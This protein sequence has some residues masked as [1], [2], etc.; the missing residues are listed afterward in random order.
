[1]SKKGKI[2]S[3]V[4]IMLIAMYAFSLSASA[5]LLGKDGFY[6]EF[7]NGNA[8]LKEYHSSSVTV[9]IPNQVYSHNVTKIADYAFLRNTNITSVTIPDTVNKIGDSAFYGCSNLEK[10][11]IPKSVI[12]FGNSIFA[13]C[14]KLTIYC[15]SGSTAEKYAIANNAAYKL[16]DV[17]ELRN[18]STI[19]STQLNLGDTL[20]IN[21]AASGGSGGYTY[22]FYY[23]QSQNAN[24]RKI[25]A[26][27]AAVSVTLKPQYLTTYD[28]MVTV[29]DGNAQVVSKTFKVTVSEE[30]K[31][32]SAI[33]TTQ[34]IKGETLTLTGAASGGSG[35]Y[36]YA[37]YY[38][39]ASTTG[40]RVIGELYGTATTATLKPSYLTE[41]DIMI[42]V[43]DSTNKMVSKT[44]K[45]TVS[46][47]L[48]NNSTISTTQ[49]IKGETLTLTGAAEGGSGEYKYAF[50]YK[51]ASTTGWRAIGELYGTATTATLKPSYLTEYDIM[52]RVKDSTGK[53]VSTTFKVNVS[54]E[55]VSDL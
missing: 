6:Y 3:A 44:F 7:E 49:L 25:S 13:N 17:E 29:K 37:F 26:D 22:E 27:P 38:K 45:V 16:V 30:L 28:I 4:L 2:I 51:Q 11:L 47:E 20:K 36:K 18:N 33:S 14:G 34:L 21:G 8:V 52:I 55:N 40:W 39:Q 5:A 35:E 54:E 32:N 1:M 50:Y 15:Y 42:R 53:I 9:E 48:K 12:S 10:V 31:N 23:K 41:Y 24:W 46:E 43:K 19:S